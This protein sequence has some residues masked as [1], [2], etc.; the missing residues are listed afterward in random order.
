MLQ[1]RFYRK[2]TISQVIWKIN[3]FGNIK[4]HKLSDTQHAQH[5]Q[6]A[7]LNQLSFTCHVVA[8]TIT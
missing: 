7:T 6:H 8:M 2:R 5:T 1:T 4:Q 3:S